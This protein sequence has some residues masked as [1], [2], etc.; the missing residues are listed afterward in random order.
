MVF[1]KVL[2]QLTLFA[3]TASANSASVFLAYQPELPSELR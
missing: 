2:A 1:F 3:A